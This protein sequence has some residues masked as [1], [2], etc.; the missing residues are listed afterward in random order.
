MSEQQPIDRADLERLERSI[1]SRV[2]RTG[3]LTQADATALKLIDLYR[4]EQ[5]WEGDDDDD[6]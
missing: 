3:G 4:K 6:R 1:R 2:R 5:G